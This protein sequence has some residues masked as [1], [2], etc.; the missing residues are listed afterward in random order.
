VNGCAKSASAAPIAITTTPSDGSSP[1]AAGTASAAKNVTHAA[2]YAAR[3]PALS[4]ATCAD[5]HD[6][7]IDRF[8][9]TLLCERDHLFTSAANGSTSVS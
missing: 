1:L 5:A 8:A 7:S 9:A 4:H 2:V 6:A 3:F